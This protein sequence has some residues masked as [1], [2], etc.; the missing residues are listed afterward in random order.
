MAGAQRW[1]ALE[2]RLISAF[3]AVVEKGSFAAAARELGYTQSGVSQQVAALERIA[4]CKLLI[5]HAGGRRPVQPTAAGR[6]ML[7]HSRALLAQIDRAY[8]DVNGRVHGNGNTVRVG[9]FSSIAVHVLPRLLIE[10][11]RQGD[12][13]LEILEHPGDDELRDELDSGA[14]DLAFVVLPVPSRFGVEELGSDPYVALVPAGSELA[15]RSRISLDD[16]R[17]R[18]LLGISRCSHED[19][20]EARFADAGLAEPGFER[21][22]DNQL[23]QS[24]VA[25]GQG[26]AVVPWLTVNHD[27]SAV[28]VLPLAVDLAPRKLGLIHH[29]D[30]LLSPA[31]REVRSVAVDL[32]SKALQQ[33]LEQTG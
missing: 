16:L 15:S 2:I 32:C 19:I 31:A 7:E 6:A 10:L 12:T 9:A 20:V 26:V 5:R 11:R 18:Q 24:L 4:D 29:R 30:R 33:P 28:R 27:D 23:V 25:G 1:A 14:V 17:G 13:R 21:Y 8:D 22:D 3:V